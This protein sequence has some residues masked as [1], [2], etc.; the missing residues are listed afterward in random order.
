MPSS[1]KLKSSCCC[2]SADGIHKRLSRWHGAQ[3]DKNYHETTIAVFGGVTSWHAPL[4][5]SSSRPR[6]QLTSP[7]RGASASC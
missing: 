1:T 6:S 7:A 5:V 4:S 3:N 2:L